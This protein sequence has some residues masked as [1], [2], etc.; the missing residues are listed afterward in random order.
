MRFDLLLRH[1]SLIDGA[2]ALGRPAGGAAISDRTA[3]VDDPSAAPDTGVGLVVR[4][5]LETGLRA[6]RLLRLG[7]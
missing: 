2:G 4:D 3:A 6:G 1:G 7:D 5:G